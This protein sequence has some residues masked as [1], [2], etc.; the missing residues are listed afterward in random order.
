MCLTNIKII[1][2][3]KVLVAPW[4]AADLDIGRKA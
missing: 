1:M 4:G 2:T 3:N